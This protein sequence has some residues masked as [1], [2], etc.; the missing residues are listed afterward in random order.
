MTGTEPRVAAP[1]VGS[2]ERSEPV[3][4]APVIAEAEPDVPGDWELCSSEPAAPTTAPWRVPRPGRPVEVRLWEL[5]RAL[6]VELGSSSAAR[7][8]LEEAT[9]ISGA[10]LWQAL[11]E[12]PEVVAVARL[13]AMVRRRA[14]GEPLAYVL[15]RWSF[16]ELTLET[17]PGALIP[18]PETEMVAEVAIGLLAAGNVKE[19]VVVDLG[20][21]TGALALSIAAESGARVLAVERSPAALALANRNLAAHP[22]LAQRVRVCPGSWFDALPA[23]LT[24]QVQLFVSNPPY[25]AE[26]ELPSLP[27]EVADHEPHEALV[28]GR[29]GLETVEVILAGARP[30]LA[31]QG[32]VVIEVAA[33]RAA[34]SMSLAEAAGYGAVRLVDDLAGRPRVLVAERCW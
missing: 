13:E 19:P 9:G 8:M 5:W 17:R 18:R 24:G 16:R 21:G 2:P 27:P 7:W 32:L 12:V 22:A 23:E 3:L 1:E 26:T 20:T 15:G 6:A 25:V 10:A 30:W 33:N 28:A 11:D 34:A 14:R 31:E 4:R 29:T